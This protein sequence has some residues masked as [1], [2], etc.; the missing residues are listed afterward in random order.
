MISGQFSYVKSLRE[1][2]YLIIG[3]SVAI[4]TSHAL[5]D[6]KAAPLPRQPTKSYAA[7]VRRSV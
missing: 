7:G 2:F 3:L 5:D 4:I 1:W 6:Q